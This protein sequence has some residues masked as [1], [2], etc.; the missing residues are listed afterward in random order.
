MQA[1]FALQTFGAMQSAVD[2]Q[3]ARQIEGELWQRKGEQSFAEPSGA[4]IV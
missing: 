2:A 3:A 4:M 1:P